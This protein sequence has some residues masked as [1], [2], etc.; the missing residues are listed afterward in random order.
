MEEVTPPKGSK[1]SRRK[2]LSLGLLAG[3]GG[4]GIYQYTSRHRLEVRHETLKLPRW[5]ANGFKVALVSDLHINTAGEIDPALESIRE[6][7]N[8]RPDAILLGGDYINWSD[9]LPFV[10]SFLKS[11]E[12]GGIPTYSVLG[13]HDFW[14]KG[15]GGLIERIKNTNIKL[16]RNEVVDIDGITIYGIDDGIEGK[17][18]HDRLTE[19][20]DSGSIIALFHEP[21]F[22]DRVDK[23]VSIMLAGHSHGGQVC[24][25]FGKPAHLPRGARKY[26]DGFYPNADVPL[27]VSRGVGMTGPRVRLFCRPDISI[28]TLRSAA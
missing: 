24:Y 22:V 8:A 17:D 15:V 1:I 11:V 4:T 21:D 19:R 5:K 7:V 25:P 27:F 28:L 2:L 18:K 10:E 6:A 12:T 9:S 16:L 3:I 13:N 23:R 20:Q 14:S 26:W